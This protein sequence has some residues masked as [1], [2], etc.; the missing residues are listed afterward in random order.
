MSKFHIELEWEQSPRT[1]AP[2]LSAT[3]ARLAIYVDDVP[4]TKVEDHRSHGVRSG[5]YVPLYPMAEWIANNWWFLWNEWRFDRPDT[6]HNLSAAREGFALPDLSFLPTETRIQLVWRQRPATE[7]DRVS[8]LMEGSQILSKDIVHEGV[9]SFVETVIQRLDDRDVPATFL[10][11]EWQ[12]IL[13]AEKDPNQKRFCQQAARLG[14]DPFDLESSIAKHLEEL[15]DLLPGSVI[16]DFCDAV[17]LS[18]ISS[19]VT[20]VRQFLGSLHERHVAQGSW[21]D[22]HEALQISSGLSPWHYGYKQAR[23]LRSSLGITGPVETDLESFRRTIGSFEVVPFEAPEGLEAIIAPSSTQAPL[24]GLPRRVVRAESRR[25][26]LC[27]ALSDYLA[28]GE[29]SLVTRTQTEHQQRN[30]AFAAE[31]LAPA[32]SIRERLVSDRL[33]EDDLEDLAQ[34]FEVSGFVIRHQI[35]NHRLATII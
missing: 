10:T 28:L 30:R 5:I 23:L 4:V 27:R 26:V 9:R 1:S 11:E 16:D 25:F 8:F 19:G 32:A 24:F 7:F 35:E 2:E 20:A 31:F 22:L 6:R 18:Q 33:W 21:M 34:E 3:W 17:T 13:E 15:D 29:P 12:A 14:Y